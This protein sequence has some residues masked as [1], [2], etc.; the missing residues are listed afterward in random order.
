VAVRDRLSDPLLFVVVTGAVFLTRLPFLSPGLGADAD[1]WRVYLAGRSIARTGAYVASRLPGYP[2]IEYSTALAWP[3]GHTVLNAMT[4]LMS[5]AAVAFF[6]LALRRLG[7]RTWSAGAAALA[8][9]PV[10]FVNS[11]VLMDY[12]WAL[13]FMLGALYFTVT[14]RPW[15]GGAFLGFAVG[16]RLTS[17]VALVPL[18]LMILVRSADPED[19]SSPGPSSAVRLRHAA[20]LV[21]TTVVVA[22][23]L[24]SPVVARYGASFFGFFESDATPKAA[25][26]RF[27]SATGDLGLVAIV[28]AL[29][30]VP[31]AAVARGPVLR[32]PVIA[33]LP[34]AWALAW[35]L[36]A[37]LYLIA[38]ARLP[39]ES[40][41]LLPVVPFALLVG[42]AV[43]DERVWL[44]ACALLALSWSVGFAGTGPV[45]GPL[46]VAQR[47]RDARFSTAQRA[48]ERSRGLGPGAVVLAGST[49]PAIEAMQLD[50]PPTSA[51]FL[52]RPDPAELGR[53]IAEGHAVYYL[54][55]VDDLMR[56]RYGTDLRAMGA[57]PLGE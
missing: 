9:V 14:R 36:G 19:A 11:G 37:A 16:C 5:A 38:Y 49:S 4:A 45:P 46:V 2:V 55:G 50:W 48:L 23:L 10:M 34:R 21:G 29:V 51:R 44:G 26:E 32:R 30:S 43:L 53:L 24:Y 12:A 42:A 17:A 18:G 52:Y 1:A 13:A 47:T 3:Y 15:L 28:L 7:A 40:G 57:R 6:A 22:G 41:Y 8:F 33:R 27:R 20:I 39:Q 25:W 56:E 54:E 31:L 35:G